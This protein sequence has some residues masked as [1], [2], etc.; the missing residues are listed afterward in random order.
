MKK[1]I[2]AVIILLGIAFTVLLILRIWGIT[3]VSSENILRSGVTL[4]VVGILVVFLLIIYGGFYLNKKQHY[5]ANT[6][7]RSHPK[8]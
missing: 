7:N 1:I 6:G 4:L 8:V 5:N 3:P 2:G